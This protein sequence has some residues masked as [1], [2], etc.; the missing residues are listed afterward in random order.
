M[1]DEA[2]PRLVAGSGM[3]ERMARRIYEKRNG[4]GRTPWPHLPKA[5]KEPYRSDARAALPALLEPTEGMVEAGGEAMDQIWSPKAGS[6]IR[7]KLVSGIIKAAIQ[8]ALAE[9]E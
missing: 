2:T 4:A 7:G 8:A 9:G 3:V 6:A 5:H 1:T